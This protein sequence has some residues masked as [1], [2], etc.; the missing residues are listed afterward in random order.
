MNGYWNNLRP[1]E[2]RVI[3]G[4]GALFFVVLNFLFVIPHFSDLNAAHDRMADAQKK[5]ERYQAEFR[6]TN[7]YVAGLREFE[8]E[9]SDVAVEEQSYQFANA[10]QAQAGQS[11]VHILSNGRINTQ[12]NQFFLEKSQTISV[13][14][15][16]SQLVDFLFNLGSGGSQ[17]RVRDLGVR[18]DQAQQ[19]LVANV[20]L[21]AS[22]QKKATGRAALPA[23]RTPI[24]PKSEAPLAK[25]GPQTDK[26]E[27]TT[28]K[29]P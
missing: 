17:I 9:G 20:K 11:G 8:K 13:Q 22:Y 27:N 29:R 25:P 6:Q 19:Q 24:P 3:V 2:K 4:F 12:T 16:E 21:V 7:S 23:S 10:I 1:F 15:G 5:L 28:T 18:P 14:G 26:T